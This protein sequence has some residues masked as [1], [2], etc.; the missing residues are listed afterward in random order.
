[1]NEVGLRHPVTKIVEEPNS[2]NWKSESYPLIIKSENG[3]SS[4]GLWL[5]N[6][7]EDVPSSE[8]IENKP[9]IIQ[10]FLNITFDIRVICV[11]GSISSFYWRIN[12]K[13]KEWRPT[14]T[15][16]GATVKFFDLPD[17]VSTLAQSIYEKTRCVTYG[18]D[19]CFRNDDLNSEPYILEFSPIYQPNPTPPNDLISVNYSSYKNGSAFR[20]DRDFETLVG[21]LIYQIIVGERVDRKDA[22]Q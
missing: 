11:R 16:N 10:E 7:Y 13:M 19:I 15:Q 3:Y 18:A 5:C 20:Y 4:N 21:H 9:L 17:S 6:S 22:S 8:I 14:A 1:M 2:Y 12:P